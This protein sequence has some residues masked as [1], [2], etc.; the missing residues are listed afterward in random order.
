MKQTINFIL[1]LAFG[2]GSILIGWH[3]YRHP[4]GYEKK[5]MWWMWWMTAVMLFG[6]ISVFL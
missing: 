4:D 3:C 6:V 1:F 2:L 5:M